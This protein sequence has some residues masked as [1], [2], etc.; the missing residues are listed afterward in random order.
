MDIECSRIAQIVLASDSP[1]RRRLV[2]FLDTEVRVVSPE[3]EEGPPL[4]GESPGNFV[5]RLSARKAEKV[6]RY[7]VDSIVMGADTAV[8]LDGVVLGKPVDSRDAVDMLRQLRG[9]IHTVIT[10]L[11][12]VDACSERRL[13]VVT[14]TEVWM[15]QYSD[16]EITSYVESDAPM[17]KAGAYAIQDT[18]FSPAE[19]VT[20]CYFNVV[21][22]PLCEVTKTLSKLGA[23][24][25]LRNDSEVASYCRQCTLGVDR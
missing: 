16:E 13:T 23:P 1:R 4:P 22:L 7:A 21:G 18:N 19:E 10:G 6:V 14:R 5:A 12:M 25:R 2:E 9:R 8:V 15:R 17:D 24:V 11:T 3:I 20:G